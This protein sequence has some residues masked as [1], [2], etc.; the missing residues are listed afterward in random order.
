[1]LSEFACG[2]VWLTVRLYHFDRRKFDFPGERKRFRQNRFLRRPQQS[3]S[4][5]KRPSPQREGESLITHR[6]NRTAHHHKSLWL[7]Q[8]RPISGQPRITV[9]AC[10][11]AG[12]RVSE[13]AGRSRSQKCLGEQNTPPHKSWRQ[14]LSPKLTRWF[15]HRCPPKRGNATVC[16][17]TKE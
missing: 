16:H 15:L 13:I 12:C 3:R 7:V 11:G 14:A 8:A 6:E 5:A 4:N 1:M 9:A 17:S 10:N 2:R